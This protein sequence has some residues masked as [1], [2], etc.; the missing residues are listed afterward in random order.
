MSASG[1]AAVWATENTREAIVAAMRRREVYAT[2][3]PRIAVR[4]YGGLNLKKP[5]LSRRRFLRIQ[6]QAVP[7]GGEIIGAANEDR[8]SLIVEAQADPKSAYLDR[9]QI[10]KGWID[11]SGQTH[12]RVFDAA[13]SGEERWL[14][15]GSVIPVGS[16]VDLKTG[17]TANTI[18][19]ARLSVVWQDPEFD[20][21][22]SAFYYAR[23][24]QIPTARHS[25]LDKLA[26]GMTASTPAGP[27]RFRSAP[28]RRRSGIGRLLV[29][30]SRYTLAGPQ[31]PASCWL[32]PADSSRLLLAVR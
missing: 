22:Q 9:I 12:E 7:M 2:S 10:I 6:S 15:D 11:A 21:K 8:F 5:P 25:L 18:G 29:T 23:V 32:A 17:M 26:L 27:I 3:G 28:I 30:R 13:V 31:E 20:S 14:A 4:T 1:L 16:S 19:S 24:L